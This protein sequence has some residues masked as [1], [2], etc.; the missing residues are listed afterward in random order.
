MSRGFSLVELSVVLV[1][2][3]LIT[4]GI[5]A[6]SSLIRSAEMQSVLTEAQHYES[7]IKQFR[8]VY[9]ALPGDMADA[10]DYWGAMTNCAAANPSGSGTQTCDGNGDDDLNNSDQDQTGETMAFWQHLANAGMIEGEYTGIAGGGGTNNAVIG[11]NTPA[12]RFT[13]GGWT[14]SRI[15]IDFAGGPN[16]F[17]AA[18]GNQLRFGAE[19]PFGGTQTRLL[20]PEQAWNID[21]KADD[22]RPGYGRVI[23]MYW[24]DLCSEALDGTSHETDLDA[25]YR[26]DD[27]S[28][29]CALIFSIF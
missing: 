28:K 21:K 26:L 8:D 9:A 1:I 15:T 19:N 11:E 13:D 20:T 14:A 2:I 12:S 18:F 7:A 5:L 25:R 10:T 3:G 17:A 4:G 29:Q 22:G 23:A 27:T 6:G 24:N 16:F